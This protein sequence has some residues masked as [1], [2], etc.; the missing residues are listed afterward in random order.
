MNMAIK[1]FMNST[2]IAGFTAIA[3]LVVAVTPCG[4]TPLSDFDHVVVDCA[5]STFLHVEIPGSASPIEMV[6]LGD[7]YTGS[8]FV[9]VVTN[10]QATLATRRHVTLVHE[11]YEGAPDVTI[12][13]LILFF[14]TG[15]HYNYDIGGVEHVCVNYSAGV[16]QGLQAANLLVQVQKYWDS[17]QPAGRYSG[18]VV[19]DL[20]SGWLGP[21]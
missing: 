18:E 1:S 2:G 20:F 5:I 11:S 8:C 12:Q 3:L 4:S 13:A 9:H 10:G 15:G 6:A 17:T 16:W 19:V 14:F 7:T 21:R